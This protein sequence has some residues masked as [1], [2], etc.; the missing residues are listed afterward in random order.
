MKNQYNLPRSMT[1]QAGYTLVQIMIAVTVVALLSIVSVKEAM[2]MWNDSKAEDT[3]REVTIIM[4][5]MTKCAGLKGGS[6]ASCDIDELV[7]LGY[8]DAE[9][10]GDGTGVNPYSG[11]YTAQQVTGN[12]NRFTVT[13]SGITSDAHCAR[14]VEFFTGR[15]KAVDCTT[16]T[17]T[18][19]N[20]NT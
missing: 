20:G 2:D 18:V 10:W 12:P 13:A 15:A 5:E 1:R 4:T 6:F 14:M 3:A 7:R 9:T 17:L 16:G 8:L 11:D 19:T